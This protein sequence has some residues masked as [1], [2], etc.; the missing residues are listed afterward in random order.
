NESADRIRVLRLPAA[1]R[2]LA[3]SGAGRDLF[4]HAAPG[5]AAACRQTAVG[6]ADRGGSLPR[7]R[8]LR[9]ASADLFD[10]A[11][12]RFAAR[13]SLSPVE[14][15]ADARP[16]DAVDY[17]IARIRHFVASYRPLAGQ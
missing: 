2:L 15:A 12:G 11:G 16:A 6:A 17:G 1:C 7:R 14:R 8:Y 3:A 10:F 5:A 13:V 9:R 4:S